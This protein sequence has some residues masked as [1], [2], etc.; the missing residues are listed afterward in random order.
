MD[1]RA[2]ALE[3]LTINGALSEED[4]L[5]LDLFTK[6]NE[7]VEQHDTLLIAIDG[8]CGSGKSVLGKRIAEVFDGNLFHMDDFYLQAY[9]RTEK[10]YAT[11]GENADHERFERE[12][13]I[14]LMHKDDV[15]YHTFNHEDFSV[16]KEYTLIPYKKINIVEGSYTL[17]KDLQKYF[18]YSIYLTIDSE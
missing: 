12:V 18:D 16:N 17:H 11:P 7:L 10:R 15:Q 6:L 4:L 13:L 14:P 3:Q 5:Y 2:K 8:M 9:Q 1:Y